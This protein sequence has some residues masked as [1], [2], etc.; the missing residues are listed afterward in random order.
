MAQ[1]KSTNV[2]GNLSA[3]GSILAPKFIKLGGTSSGFLKADGSVDTT[4][5]T[6][7]TGTVTSIAAGTGL[8]GGTITTTGTISLDVA[9]AKTALGLGSAAYTNSEA[10]ATS[11]QGTNADTAHGWGN[12]AGAGY[13]TSTWNVGVTQNS[14]SGVL[15]N[16]GNAKLKIYY[17][18]N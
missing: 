17:G 4:A 7:N 2:T 12:H 15:F 5:Y 10:Y 13:L 18:G 14:N 3:T 9:G 8:S 6:T 11:T 1:L 16:N